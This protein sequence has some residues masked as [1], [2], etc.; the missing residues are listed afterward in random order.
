[1]SGGTGMESSGGA[2][3][4]DGVAA[5]TSASLSFVH[6]ARTRIVPACHAS[7]S[8]LYT[9]NYCSKS[10]QPI[11]AIGDANNVVGQIVTSFLTGTN[12][13][14]SLGQAIEDNALGSTKGGINL[15]L[16]DSKG[17]PQ[18]ISATTATT[19]AGPLSLSASKQVLY[20]EMLPAGAS[21]PFQIQS[22][23]VNIK[24]TA[25]TVLPVISKPGPVIH[26]AVPAGGAVFPY[27]VAPGA[28]VAIYG[29]SLAGST[30][31]AA[32]PNFPQQ[33]GDVQVS[34]NDASIPIQYISA[35]QLNVIWPD[36][37][38][39]LTKLTVTSAAGS[40]T[41]NVIVQAAVPTVFTFDG[42]AAA[43]INGVSGADVGSG[44]PLRAGIDYVSLFLTGLGGTTNTN[45]LD[46][47]VIQPTLTV[48]GQPCAV[49]Y[50]GRVPGVPA[51]DQINCQI[52]AGISGAAVPV[53]VTSNGRAANTVTLNIK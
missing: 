44:A 12:A 8:L 15:Q 9:F 10:A 52:P 13:W 51:L 2:G 32:G 20:S 33:L 36:L 45:G 48:G 34:V 14:Q 43:A 5:L 6:T 16:Q 7:I 31:V 4:D 46:Y 39:G 50:A 24:L 1:G 47:A 49:T 37:P 40:F 11:A 22:S 53:V 38:P 29:T 30:L 23:P 35:G 3:F 19:T 42:T 26:G 21:L 18:T 25:G 27:D 28:Y 17:V 41:T